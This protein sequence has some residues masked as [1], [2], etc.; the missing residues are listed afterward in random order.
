MHAVTAFSDVW[1]GLTTNHF[2][3]TK[4]VD[5]YMHASIPMNTLAMVVRRTAGITDAVNVNMQVSLDGDTW[6]TISGAQGIESGNKKAVTYV[7][8]GPEIA[9]FTGCPFCF[10]R[11]WIQSVGAGN[12]LEIAMLASRV[13]SGV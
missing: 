9:S 13:A 4:S 12:T 1:T 11:Y 5:Q 7:G 2:G 8:F 6:V 3:P 10:F